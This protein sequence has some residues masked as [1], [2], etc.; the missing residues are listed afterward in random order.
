[1]ITIKFLGASKDM[2]RE[3][4]VKRLTLPVP[5]PEQWEYRIFFNHRDEEH[6]EVTTDAET[7]EQ[8][9]VKK[10]IPTAEYVSVQADHDPTDEEW[11]EVLAE[12]GYTEEQITNIL[13]EANGND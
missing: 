3:K 4:G 10:T 1:M 8:S 6:E 12:Q 2:P 13:S 11:T 7:G 5:T 9:V